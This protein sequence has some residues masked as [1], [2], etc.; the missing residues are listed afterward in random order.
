MLQH[1]LLGAGAGINLTFYVQQ[2][3]EL[4][5][6]TRA[7]SWKTPS[8]KVGRNFLNIL[9]E[10]E[11]AFEEVYVASFEVLDRIWL[12]RAASYM[13]FPTVLNDTM[14]A[15]KEALLQSPLTIADLRESLDLSP[16]GS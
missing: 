15:V 1:V 6:P 11:S 16:E 8:S 2:L 12:E 7:S 14:S 10:N 5:S 13:E 4:R 9:D 3:L